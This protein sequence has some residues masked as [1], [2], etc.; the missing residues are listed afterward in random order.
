MIQRLKSMKKSNIVFCITTVIA[1]AAVIVFLCCTLKRNGYL[2]SLSGLKQKSIYNDH[3]LERQLIDSGFLDKGVQS[4]LKQNGLME[5]YSLKSMDEIIEILKEYPS[6]YETAIHR[7]D[8]YSVGFGFPLFGVSRWEE[9]IANCALHRPGYIVMAQFSA[10]FV[11]TYYYIEYDG[12]RYHVVEDRSRDFE[13]D[14]SGYSECYGKYLRVEGYP[15][16]AGFAE[17]AY[18]TDDV[19]MTYRKAEEYYRTDAPD[20]IIKPSCWSFYVG[21]VTDEIIQNNMITPDRNDPNFKTGYTGFLD[22]HPDYVG[23]NPRR[24]YDGDGI[25]D[26]VYREHIVFEDGSETTNAYLMFG[27]GNCIVLAKDI[28]GDSLKTISADVHLDD[29][30]DISFIEYSNK[31]GEEMAKLYVFAN[32]SGNFISEKLPVNEAKSIEMVVAESDG[33]NIFDL[34]REDDSEYYVRYKDGEWMVQE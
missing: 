23:D 22:R 12:S 9:F 13:D 25:L 10:N 15:T 30:P 18:L 6:D 1:L 11:G 28:T 32:K 17:Y 29:N 19:S 27:N 8:I 24:D 7:E 5:D 34:V 14:Q 26:R 16:E 2:Y 21:V 3:M 31:P 33:N 20:A 4:F